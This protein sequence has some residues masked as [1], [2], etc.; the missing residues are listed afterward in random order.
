MKTAVGLFLGFV[1][2]LAFT[3]CD[4]HSEPYQTPTR[5]S[6]M[7]L[8]QS[9]DD[10]IASST[11]HHYAF[12]D[13]RIS[14]AGRLLV[15]LGSAGSAPQNYA[16]LN[17]TATNLGYYVI[18]LSYL[19]SIDGQACASQT[20]DNCFANFHEE[21]IFG[22]DKST[23]IGINK[24]S[25]LTN[26]ILKLLQHLHKLNSHNGWD[27]FYEGNELLYSKFVLAGH[28]QGGGHAAYLAQKV[29]ANRLV[30]FSSPNDFSEVTGKPAPWLT[31]GFATV[32]TEFYG[33]THKKDSI[34]DI[35][36]QY[37]IWKGMG[38][39][40]VADT[41]TADSSNFGNSKGLVTHFLPNPKT[42]RPPPA[43]N[44]RTQLKQAWTYV[45]G[46]SSR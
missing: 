16:S 45:L 17:K 44:D 24:F 35:S 36:K 39:L 43:G 46:Y 23:L 6:Y 14:Q 20:D 15:F 28:G 30:V 27:Q 34:L 9:T 31:N 1:F 12:V 22:V 11:V 18:N 13:T 7:V 10:S 2:F 38:M 21:M 29:S 33:L 19:N 41:V 37:A 32:A 5:F 25:C 3:G 4:Q 26:R 42:K 8:P 40:E